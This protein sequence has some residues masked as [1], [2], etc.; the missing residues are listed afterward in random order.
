MPRC[1]TNA[2]FPFAKVLDDTPTEKSGAPENG[3]YM[4]G[5][6]CPALSLMRIAVQHGKPIVVHRV[7]TNALAEAAELPIGIIPL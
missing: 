1:N 5:H 7:R 6:G 4:D 3:H 2:K